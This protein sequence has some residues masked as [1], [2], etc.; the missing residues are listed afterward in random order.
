[1]AAHS[2]SL[3]EA[4]RY[5]GE[6]EAIAAD[7]GGRLKTLWFNTAGAGTRLR[8][9]ATVFGSLAPVVLRDGQGVAVR[10]S[11]SYLARFLTLETEREVPP[12][13]LDSEPFLGVEG[14]DAP[15]AAAFAAAV[16]RATGYSN[17]I[18]FDYE[19]ALK[20]GARAA[21][22]LGRSEVLR[23][24]RSSVA[25]MIDGRVIRGRPRVRGYQRMV[26]SSRPCAACMSAAGRTFAGSDSFR[27][28]PGCG[29]VAVPV[30]ENLPDRHRP[31]RG[32]ELFHK[33]PRD[34]Q[35]RILGPGPA[36]AI[37]DGTPLDAFA[38]T[39]HGYLTQAP[40]KEATA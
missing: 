21:A 5:A 11:D 30:V 25:W 4:R 35:D 16:G 3:D 39:D 8:D 23:A 36:Q 28:H 9:A 26:T 34:A 37:R 7:T 20:N 38:T 15:P 14:T 19:N 2:K 13:G 1:M 40:L 24:G 18:G 31:P 10:S 32:E 27:Y 6:Q 22:R 17:R 29:C 33:L 12:L